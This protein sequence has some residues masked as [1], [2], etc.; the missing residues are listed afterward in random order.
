MVWSSPGMAKTAM[1]HKIAKEDKKNL[2]IKIA[3]GMDPAST[4]GFAGVEGKWIY[5]NWLPYDNVPG[6]IFLDEVNTALP[7]VLAPLL[8]FVQTG[9]MG[10]YTLPEKYGVA[11][12]GNLETDRT[13]VNRL[14]TAFMNRCT[15]IDLEVDHKAWFDDF[16]Y[17]NLCEEVMAYLMKYESDLYQ[18][19]PKS[20]ERCFATLRTWDHANRI[21]KENIPTG[22]K[23]ELLCGTIGKGAAIKFIGFTRIW[24]KLPDLD[25]ALKDPD[26]YPVPLD[27]DPSVLYATVGS[28]I[29]RTDR[30]TANGF[31][32]YIMRFP[33]EFSMLYFI[34]ASR[35]Y[36]SLMETPAAKDFLDKH[37]NNMTW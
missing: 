10:Q 5:P 7:S 22:I 8:Q 6:I 19:D 32:R 27:Q 13:F 36:K 29:S 20:G 17:E 35:K 34:G 4:E 26:N 21:W 33:P 14:G 9:H 2:I 16:G 31:S 15:H 1:M 37:G 28:M 3:S 30:K 25:N 12:A 23:E 18:F 11:L 24:E